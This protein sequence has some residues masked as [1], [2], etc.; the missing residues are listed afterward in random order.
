M[1]I[2]AVRVISAGLAI[3]FLAQA[4]AADVALTVYNNDRALVKESRV[5]DIKK[6]VQ[7][8]SFD[9]I[10]QRIDPTTVLVKIDGAKVLEQ[11]YNYDLQ[12]QN[13]LLS[14]YIGK[15]ITINDKTTQTKISGVLL[16]TAGGL[17]VKN[18]DNII[19]NPQGAVTLTPASNVHLK[20]SLMWVLESSVAGKKNA[21]IV[22]QTS[23]IN[24][25]ADYI[26]TVN[27]ANTKA[28][29][30]SW[31]TVNN[32]SGSAYKNAKLTL[33]AGDINTVSA[34]NLARLKN[35]PV[36]YEAAASP[37]GAQFTGG[38]VFEYHAYALAR[39]TTLNDSESKQLEFLSVRNVA[40]KKVYTFNGSDMRDFYFNSYARGD[41]N[42]GLNN[43][44]KVNVS[45]KF[46]NDKAGAL[47]KGRIRVYLAG[48]NG[49]EFLGEDMINHTPKNSEVIVN[50]GSAFDIA[51]VRVQTDFKTSGNNIEESFKITLKNSKDAP[52]TVEI[53]EPLYRWNKWKILNSS[54]KYEKKDY[55]T[56]AF[57]VNVPSGGETDVTYT[58]KYSW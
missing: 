35:S 25:N 57:N 7:N 39:K 45:F 27:A 4:A 47:P 26:L 50:T 6:G 55:K 21:E 44:A 51:G 19:L 23:G 54:H 9:S 12:N 3:L 17:V 37:S 31:V 38:D 53:I 42:F 34:P 46:K 11:T 15:E 10:P 41:K 52:V 28:D 33:I 32:F 16:S 49:L 43:G 18:K 8:I 14:R 5:V 20:P 56:I 2:F 48:T 1:R 13:A 40:V 58:V 30:A 24:W 22:Y 36:L 29:I